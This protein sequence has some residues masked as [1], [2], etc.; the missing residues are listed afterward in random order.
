M[1]QHLQVAA[2]LAALF[3]S[4]PAW[5]DDVAPAPAETKAEAV[6]VDDFD[7]AVEIAKKEKKDLLVDFTGSDWC[8]WCIR[9]H[10]EVFAHDEFLSAA[11]KQ[12]VLVAL[13]FP[14]GEDAKA[15]VPNPARNQE[16]AKKYGVQ[17]YPTIL[18]VTPEGDVFGQ[19]GYQPGGPEKYVE[20]VTR[21]REEGLGELTAAKELLRLIKD[22]KGAERTAACEKAI[23][24]L[25]E[26]TPD[27][28]KI[29]IRVNPVKAAL[30]SDPENA[31][32]IA[33]KALA[34]MFK[35]GAADESSL[36]AAKKFDPKNES[37]LLE[38]A[39]HVKSMML[40]SLDEAKA[41]A[42]W[43]DELFAMGA[44]KDKNIEKRLSV[45]CAFL[46]Q[47]HLGDPAKAVEYAK[48]AKALG[49]EAG[50]ER[51]QQ[52]V[53]SVLSNEGKPPEKPNK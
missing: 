40:A 39:V 21:L 1:R 20:H 50:E 41:L 27:S 44:I 37:G 24:A 25:A 51:M 46:Y 4:S 17:G 9:L 26:L 31:Q 48:R 38:Q 8:G 13:D 5:A 12:Y 7:K 28:S 42:K 32:G 14:Q 19:T 3:V 36:A 53:E 22:G 16:L 10:K 34:A 52:I 30:A 18:L 49:F 15:K 23:A 11:R 33:A 47:I 6:W 45:T 29:T 43:S 2:V 35:V